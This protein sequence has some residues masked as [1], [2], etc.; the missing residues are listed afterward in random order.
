MDFDTDKITLQYLANDVFNKTQN[1]TQNKNK[2]INHEDILFYKKRLLK[3][4][5]LQLKN[6]RINS[7][8]D[9]IFNNYIS[10]LIYI[11]KIEDRNEEIQNTLKIYNVNNKISKN[12]NNIDSC[13]NID[14]SNNIDKIMYKNI[15]KKP[16]IERF[17]IN[18][19]KKEI[20]YPKIKKIN[21]KTE[22]YKYKYNKNI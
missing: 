2:I 8:I 3:V 15:I 19:N 20:N 18:K 7:E 11:F 14:S 6:G 5:K 22:Y 9:N 4:F 17:V 12:S 10:N 13:N 1:K 16:N 21:I